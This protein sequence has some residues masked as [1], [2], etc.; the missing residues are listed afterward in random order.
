VTRAAQL[1]PHAKMREQVVMLADPSE[2][3]RL[4]LQKAAE[5]MGLDLENFLA[6]S[7]VEIAKRM[8]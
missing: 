7:V 1:A 8:L 3:L 2:A 5:K 4:R 6:E